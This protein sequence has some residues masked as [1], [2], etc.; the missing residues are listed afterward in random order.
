[1]AKPTTSKKPTN[2]FNGH[3]N[4]T[5]WNVALYFCN[6]EPTYRM[7]CDLVDRLGIKGA[8]AALYESIGGTKTPDG[9]VYTKRSIAHGLRCATEE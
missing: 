8:T 5:L 2:G 7:C 1:M 4:W 3:P 9:A 6:D